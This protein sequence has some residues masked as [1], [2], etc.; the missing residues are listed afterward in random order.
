MNGVNVGD[1]GQLAFAAIVVR[2]SFSLIRFL[3]SK[4]VSNSGPTSPIWQTIITLNAAT[5]TK[6]EELRQEVDAKFR[7][8]E[9][10]LD[11]GPVGG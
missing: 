10:R 6:I 8:L 5:H 1:L 9:A 3:Q 7:E 11:N 2:E 4:R